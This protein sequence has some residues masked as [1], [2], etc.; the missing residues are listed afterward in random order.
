MAPIGFSA[1][2]KLGTLIQNK[3]PFFME[4][5][6]DEGIRKSA[7]VKRVMRS[8]AAYEERMG[9]EFVQN[10]PEENYVK[11]GI[12]HPELSARTAALAFIISLARIMITQKTPYKRQKR[13]AISQLDYTKRYSGMGEDEIENLTRRIIR[14]KGLTIPASVKDFYRKYVVDWPFAKII[15]VVKPLVNDYFRIVYMHETGAVVT[16]L[17]MVKHSPEK[18]LRSSDPLEF[19]TN[20]WDEFAGLNVLR[21]LYMARRIVNGMEG[22]REG[23]VICGYGHLLKDRVFMT[24]LN[25]RFELRLVNVE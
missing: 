3:Y 18:A 4:G 2:D 17:N 14:S 5:I 9:L 12:D 19:L 6:F 23:G 21:E 24:I 1:R 20:I 13:E 25:S 8:A 7:S 11:I 16:G 22:Y 15:H 10:A